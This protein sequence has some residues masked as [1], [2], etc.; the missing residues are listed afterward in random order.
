MIGPRPAAV[1]SHGTPAPLVSPSKSTL[2]GSATAS[3][4]RI[5]GSSSSC[6]GRRNSARS[7]E[8]VCNTSGLN[9]DTISSMSCW[10]G[11]RVTATQSARHRAGA[12]RR[13]AIPALTWR[14]DFANTKPI[15]SAPASSAAVTA[16]GVV[17]P[18]ILIHTVMSSRALHALHPTWQPPT[19]GD[20]PLASAR[21]QLAQAHI[22]PRQGDA[23][24]R[25]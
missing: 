18:Q 13:S 23:H 7:A 22:P 24:P 4:P 2:R 20:P 5:T 17:R 11:C 15:A 19:R 3:A 10:L 16:S 25:R 9:T 12:A 21:F 6:V 1:Q 8:S 14:T